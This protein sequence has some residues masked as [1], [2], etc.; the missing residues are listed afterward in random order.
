MDSQGY[1]SRYATYSHEGFREGVSLT[2][3]DELL[4]WSKYAYG[5]SELV[6]NPFSDWLRK[7]P[8]T[9]IFIHFLKSDLNSFSKFTM[10][11]YIGTYYAIA[12]WP[13]L[14]F[15]YFVI[16]WYQYFTKQAFVFLNEGFGVFMSVIL[17]FNIVS[18][19][20]CAA[21]RYRAG[22]SPF[23]QALYENFKWSVP[24]CIFL[25]GLSMHL[26]YALLAHLCSLVSICPRLRFSKVADG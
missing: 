16:G 11:S 24:L 25:G 22:K 20:S 19:I 14:I 23:W 6:F 1:V 7:G 2:C 15:N 21:S 8:I 18:P 12:L 3:Y 17:V 5:C 4:R 10:I 26:S 9:E 13:M